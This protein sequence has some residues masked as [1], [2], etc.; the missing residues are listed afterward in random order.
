MRPERGGARVS[1][2][3]T[4]GLRFLAA[5]AKSKKKQAQIARE[6][7]FVGA[8]YVSKLKKR[9]TPPPAETCEKLARSLGVDV[10]WLTYGT[11]E[12]GRTVEYDPRYEFAN[13]ARDAEIAAGHLPADVDRWIDMAGL[14]AAN[15]NPAESVAE[16]RGRIIGARNAERKATQIGRAV[17]SGTTVGASE[18]DDEDRRIE[19]GQRRAKKKGK[20]T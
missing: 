10:A 2:V 17:N 6:C 20:R 16:A 18:A 12:P 8:G 5:L 15:G 4:F 3:E 7:G 13:K 1:A 9:D 19:R 14:R 11:R